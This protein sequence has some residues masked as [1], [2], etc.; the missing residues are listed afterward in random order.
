MSTDYTSYRVTKKTLARL[1]K[2]KIGGESY[3][4]VINRFLDERE[5]NKLS[6]V[7]KIGHIHD[8]LQEFM[9]DLPEKHSFVVD[10]VVLSILED[11][12]NDLSGITTEEL[13]SKGGET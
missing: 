11:I 5:F 10:S 6:L 1:E 12:H 4:S 7:K 13:Y 8:L 9:S 3:E 2:H